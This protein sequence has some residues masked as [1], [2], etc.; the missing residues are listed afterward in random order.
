M[1]KLRNYFLAGLIV[2]LPAVVSFYIL[3]S[4]FT[5]FD[6]FFARWIGRI[7]VVGETLVSIP[8][9][10]LFL[11]V[12][13]IM[14]VGLFTANIVGRRVVAYGDK[15]FS[16]TPV[17]RTIYNTV[18]QIVDAFAIS[19]NGAFQQV[20]LVEYPREGLFALGFLTS[21]IKGEI[22]GHI[23]DDI[24]AVFIPTTPNPTS[25]MLIFVPRA[26]VKVLAMSV[27]EGLKLIVSGGMVSPNSN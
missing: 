14:L 8:G 2:I 10:G 15:V 25:G 1:K 13:S 21:K 17:I 20:V 26:S 3:L 23:A 6:G 5:Y 9:V 16:R 11:T 19:G 4:L 22:A 12:L 27:D 7:P 18:K 24:V